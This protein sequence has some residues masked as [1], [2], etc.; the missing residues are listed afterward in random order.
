M[1]NNTTWDNT[2]YNG[3]DDNDS[4][5]DPSMQKRKWLMIG[6]FVVIVVLGLVLLSVSIAQIGSSSS[7][8]TTLPSAEN[9]TPTLQVYIAI[10]EGTPIEDIEKIV[11]E[12]DDNLEVSINEAEA[13]G[14]IG[15]PDANEKITFYYYNEMDMDDGENE[16]GD[17]YEGIG[18]RTAFSLN[19]E[20]NENEVFRNIYYEPSQKAY[21]YYDGNDYFYSYNSKEE[22]IEAF[23][24]DAL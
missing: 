2:D 11:T 9:V 16:D 3:Q 5:A 21:V 4:W 6:I 14:E 18:P 12:I 15:T 10:S 23:L 8:T 13:A 17:D 1:K 7:D 22:A 20:S 24:I 19:Y